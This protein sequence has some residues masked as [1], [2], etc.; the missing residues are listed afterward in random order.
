L[1]KEEDEDGNQCRGVGISDQYSEDT[2]TIFKNL[3]NDCI[4]S[5]NKNDNNKTIF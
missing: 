4:G 3:F 1:R 2:Q 5:V